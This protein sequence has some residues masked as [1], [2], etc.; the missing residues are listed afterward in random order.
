M[1]QQLLTITRNTFTESIRQPIFAVVVMVTTIVLVLSP[2]LAAYTFENDT[3]MMIDMGLSS[4]FVAGLLL[5]VFT[6]TGSLSTEIENRTVLTVVSKPVPRPLFVL[7]KFLGVS[8]AMAMATW[9]L[10]IIFLLT[11]RHGVMQTARDSFD[12]P[13]LTFGILAGL[14]ALVGA[15]LANY[16]Y[17]W[18]FTSTFVIALSMLETLAWGLVLLISKDWQFQSPMTNL[19]GQLLMTLLMLFEALIILTAIA[20]AASTR[21]GQTM[22]LMVCFGVFFMGLVSHWIIGHFVQSSILKTVFL[23]LI[24]NLQYLWHAD[25]LTQGLLIEPSHLLLVSGYSFVYLVTI[26]SIAIAL[27][28]TRE[29]G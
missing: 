24:P 5:A 28:Q 18:V 6:A 29:V 21:L 19:D 3:K 4:L 15:G 17:Q 9:I 25:T 23:A 2:S 10:I 27:F 26:L 1:L 13:V 8:S 16:F 20:L 11:V 14:L 22:T 7:G 12:G